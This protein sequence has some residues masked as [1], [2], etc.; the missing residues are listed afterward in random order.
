MEL[1]TLVLKFKGEIFSLDMCEEKS[2]YI[3]EIL[4]NEF[5]KISTDNLPSKIKEISIC[6]KF[7]NE[8]CKYL[9]YIYLN[10]YIGEHDL[11][12]IDAFLNLCII[13]IN[14]SIKRYY[15]DFQTYLSL[16]VTMEL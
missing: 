5:Q 10:D 9:F 4:N 3:N 7:E 14:D 2:F 11:F 8:V 6:T 1:N 13:Q 15:N 12:I 16:M